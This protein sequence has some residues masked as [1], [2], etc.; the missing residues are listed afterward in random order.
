MNGSDEEND[1]VAD[2]SNEDNVRDEESPDGE[3]EFPEE[4]K[5]DDEEDEVTI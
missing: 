4:E 5:G 3:E 1:G 2:G